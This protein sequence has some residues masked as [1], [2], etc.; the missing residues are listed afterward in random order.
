MDARV[1][2]LLASHALASTAMSVPWPLL[3]VLVWE[4]THSPALL[5]ATAAARMVPYVVCS[6]WV[7][8]VG[9]RLG[10]DLVVRATLLARLVLLVLVALAL[11]AHE[12]L[13][14]VVL[15]TA[16]IAAATPSYPALAATVPAVA[17]DDQ[18]RVTELLVTIEV[19]G[20]MV[21][22]ALGGL[23]LAVPVATMPVAIC[24]TG[25][26]YLLMR[27]VRLP[28]ADRS[29]ERTVGC[30][31]TVRRSAPIR[32][33]LA[34]MSLL[35]V[36]DVTVGL[37]LLLMAHGDWSSFLGD[38]RAY[39]VASGALGFGTLAA[40]ALVRCGSDSVGRARAG[41][42]LMVAGVLVT[43]GSPTVV[44]AVLPLA[45]AGAATVHAESAATAIIQVEA[46]DEV[47]ASM[48]GLAD[49]CMVGAAL[50]GALLAPLVAALVTAQALL[51]GLALMG[52]AACALLRR[53]AAQPRPRTAVPSRSSSAST[54]A[55]SP[56][57]ANS[58]A[59]RSA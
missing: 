32:R 14:A 55:V 33:A 56:A 34:F 47:R 35:N 59:V 42:L 54:V 49:S 36:L 25:A 40:P 9:D 46:P 37:T 52:G 48:F 31:G 24:A 10:R 20:F 11:A 50:A 41:M 39:G 2:R 30:W 22:P 13:V 16:S 51:L 58:A 26:A 29:G 21:G 5:G 7:A 18:A 27:G 38:D 19:A 6:W 57:E 28:T 8:R 1:L 3:L 44:W 4:G 15:A 45:L 17:R 53:D 23:L 43:A 12:P